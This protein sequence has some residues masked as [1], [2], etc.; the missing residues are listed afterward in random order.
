MQRCLDLAQ[1]GL[2]ETYPNPMVGAV[3][4]HKNQII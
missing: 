1:K 4:V 3:I 2:G